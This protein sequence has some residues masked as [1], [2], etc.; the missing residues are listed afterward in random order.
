MAKNENR[1][2]VTMKCTECGAELRPTSKNKRN[3]PDRLEKKKYCSKCG[4]Q[5]VAKEKK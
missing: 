5:V 3:N 1:N 4:K 2:F